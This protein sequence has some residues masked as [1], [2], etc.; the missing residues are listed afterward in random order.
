MIYL[1]QFYGQD[2]RSYLLDGQ[3]LVKDMSDGGFVDELT[4]V[5][6]VWKANSTL[7]TYIR[8]GHSRSGRVIATGIIHV[9]ELDFA[10]QLTTFRVTGT[11]DVRD[12]AAAIARFGKMFMG[13]LWDVFVKKAGGRRRRVTQGGLN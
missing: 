11:S 12:Q 10:K 1:L 7:Y 8:E 3:K 4:L 13:T 9:R 2:G 6:R 5:P